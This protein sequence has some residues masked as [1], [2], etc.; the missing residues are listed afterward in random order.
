VHLRVLFE[1][2]QVSNDFEC[3]I[4]SGRGVKFIN[5]QTTLG[6]LLKNNVTKF[7]LS[8]NLES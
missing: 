1:V 3:N 4:A 7:C 2:T 6:F 8:P 5:A